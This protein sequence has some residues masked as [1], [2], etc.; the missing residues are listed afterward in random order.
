MTIVIIWFFCAIISAII[1]SNKG[2]SGFGWFFLG[3][4]IGPFAFAVAILPPIKEENDNSS[5]TSLRKCPYCAE[6]IQRE[7]I[8]CR[9]CG[10]DVPVLTQ[11]KEGR[12][13]PTCDYIFLGKYEKEG[14]WCPNCKKTNDNNQ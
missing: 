13:C 4:L 10:S 2:R 12:K 9:F 11:L 6:M 14:W 1:A 8:K 7:A 3:L 5:D